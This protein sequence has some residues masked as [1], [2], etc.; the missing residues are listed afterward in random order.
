[1]L[2]CTDASAAALGGSSNNF[3]PGRPK[4]RFAQRRLLECMLLL[5]GVPLLALSGCG[6]GAASPAAPRPLTVLVSAETAGWI[7][8]CGC[9]VKQAG[10]LLRRAS[11][12]KQ[13][14]TTADVLLADAG[15]APGGAAL[16]DLD[17]FRA[18][19]RGERLMGLAAH[20]LGAAEL[21]LGPEFLKQVEA[22]VPF[23]SANSA[24]SSGGALAPP[25]RLCQVRD[26]RVL[27]V[28]VVSP[29][30]ATTEIQV[31]DA[32]GAVLKVLREATAPRDLVLVLAFLPE[33]ELRDLARQVPE[34][35]LFVGGPTPQSIPPQRSGRSWLAAVANKG[36][37]LARF[38]GHPQEARLEW[39]GSIVELGPDI[40]DD[41]TQN[42]NLNRWR[43][44]LLERDFH[45]DE[46]GFAPM[47][48][49][50]L[51]ADYRLAAEQSCRECHPG[52]H[53]T[54]AESQ[55]A[56]AWQTLVTVK[57]HGDS[58]CQQCHTTGYGLP[59]G[60]QSL[61][62]STA[63]VN[64]SCESC[65]GPSQAHANRPATK[66]PLVARDQCVKCHDPENDPE[67]DFATYWPQIEHGAEPAAGT[68][69]QAG[70]AAD[71][72]DADSVK[73]MP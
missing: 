27:V 12:A 72:V 16:Y 60:F 17:K 43:Q 45:A 55:H 22:E 66:T 21:E 44:A 29:Q 57:A 11:Y 71:E 50:N 9:S 41:P 73:E 47:L 19:L 18:M 49:P 40:A 20:N 8:P 28:G 10:G 30:F 56:H 7:V 64:V 1:M 59:G 52:D 68:A 14:A 53:E 31:S 15:G 38:D 13:V 24:L 32:A 23:V 34:V 46:T 6:R 51:P 25:Y 35:D 36:K 62:Q 54:W 42:D 2:G 37:F 70:T 3:P 4:V 69:P 48:P 61:A 58:Y 65:H 67:F 39:A 26:R 33:D 63:Q 5:S